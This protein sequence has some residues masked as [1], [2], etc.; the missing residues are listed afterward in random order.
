MSKTVAILGA[1]QNDRTICRR[2]YQFIN[3]VNESL[4]LVE[5]A[6]GIGVGVVLSLD[7]DCHALRRVRTYGWAGYVSVPLSHTSDASPAPASH[8]PEGSRRISKSPRCTAMI[9]M[10]FEFRDVR[11]SN[12]LVAKT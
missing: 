7:V 6:A 5:G 1:C 9:R 11:L 8:A 2:Y 12:V 10:G 4:I 3:K